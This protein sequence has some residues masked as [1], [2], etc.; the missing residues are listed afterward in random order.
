MIPWPALAVRAVAAASAAAASVEWVAV[1]A[2]PAVGASPVGGRQAGAV[3][4]GAFFTQPVEKETAEAARPEVLRERIQERSVCPRLRPLI[5]AAPSHALDD[6]AEGDRR[7]CKILT[8]SPLESPIP[9]RPGGR[10]QS[11]GPLMQRVDPDDARKLPPEPVPTQKA[12]ATSK[13]TNSSLG[14]AISKTPQ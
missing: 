4:A 5:A 3:A 11:R 14:S 12:I 1:P 2:V 6:K 10:S 9:S 13:M 7:P 8:P